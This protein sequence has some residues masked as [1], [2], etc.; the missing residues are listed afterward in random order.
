M[1]NNQKGFASMVLIG[2]IVVLVAVGG[3]FAFVKKSEPITQQP[4]QAPVTT[5]ENTPTPIT[6]A[7]NVEKQNADYQALINETANWKTYANTQYG[8]E[9]KYPSDWKFHDGSKFKK[10]PGVYNFYEFCDQIVVN[11]P[12]DTNPGLPNCVN[13]RLSIVVSKLT[14]PDP[15]PTVD[16]DP[17]LKTVKEDVYIGGIKGVKITGVGTGNLGQLSTFVVRNKNFTYLIEPGLWPVPDQVI[18]TFKFTK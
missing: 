9:F 14:Q 17:S 1:K 6:Q 4:V 11:G 15:N 16:T 7:P 10:Q 3:Y 5:Q 18:S 8:F 2:V 12:G 13:N